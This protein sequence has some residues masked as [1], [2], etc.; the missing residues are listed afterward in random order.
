[1]RLSYLLKEVQQASMEHC[2]V[3]GIGLE[4]LQ[5]R[6]QAFLLARQSARFFRAPKGASGCACAPNHGFAAFNTREPRA[7]SR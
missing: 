4:Y 1:M 6:N 5:P 7:F 3:L 2:D